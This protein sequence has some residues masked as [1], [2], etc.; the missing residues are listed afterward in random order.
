MLVAQSCPTFCTP[1][2]VARQAPLSMEF[3][4]QE[5]WGGLSFLSPGD[6]P[7]PGMEPRSPA[8]QAD[9][10][11]SGSECIFHTCSTSQFGWAAIQALN[12]HMWLL[13][14][15]LNN[16][17]LEINI[18]NW[19]IVLGRISQRG[20]KSEIILKEVRARLDNFY[21]EHFLMWEN[22]NYLLSNEST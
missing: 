8:L 11:L 7:D 21:E 14:T 16:V 15:M 9:S 3:S 20:W 13:A 17:A 6:L 2:T 12:S 10:L 19:L 5:F 1:W 22:Y 4:R 18:N